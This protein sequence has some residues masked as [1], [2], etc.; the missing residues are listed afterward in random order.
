MKKRFILIC[1]L[2]ILIAGCSSPKPQYKHPETN[3]LVRLVEDAAQLV[4]SQGAAA[5]PAFRQPGSKWLNEQTYIFVLD[6]QGVRIVYPTAPDQEGKSLVNLYDL[7]YGKPIGKM[8][9]ATAL[10]GKAGWV[11][12]P[13]PKPGEDTP[14]WKSSYVVLVTDPAGKKYIVGSGLYEMKMERQFVVTAVDEAARLIDQKGK[15]AFATLR[16]PASQFYFKDTYVFVLSLN[17]GVE[18]LNPAY[19][20]LEGKNVLDLKDK[21]GTYLVREMIKVAK[22]KGAGWVDYMWPKPG[23]K[24]IF[25]K[26]TYIRKAKMDGRDVLVGCGVYLD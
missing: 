21:H 11:H 14:S 3:A 10:A 7:F 17:D 8:I 5:F 4:K 15:R 1:G 24:G 20:Q 23:F 22:D 16:D 25:K 13:W 12:Y 2:I 18:L 19:R 9:L 26:S 6:E